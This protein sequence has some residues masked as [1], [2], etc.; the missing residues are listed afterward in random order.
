M[1]SSV[2]AFAVRPSEGRPV[3]MEFH[4]LPARALTNGDQVGSGETI[5]SVSAGIRTP[6]GK[7][8]VTLE[9][10]GRCRPALWGAYT[11]INVRRDA[12]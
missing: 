8:E 5:I 4:K 12:Q 9:K 1:A 2:T 10:D 6:R 11:I 3:T 7:V